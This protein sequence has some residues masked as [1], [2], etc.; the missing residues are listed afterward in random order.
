MSDWQ[1]RCNALMLMS[2]NIARE[3]LEKYAV[4]YRRQLPRTPLAIRVLGPQKGSEIGMT[5]ESG[6]SIVCEMPQIAR[7]LQSHTGAV[8]LAERDLD[9]SGGL[10]QYLLGL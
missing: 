6:E 9:E 4:F 10:V 7:S 5:I 2:Q 3:N 1:K 8:P